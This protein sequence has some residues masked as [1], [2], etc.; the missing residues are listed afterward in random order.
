MALTQVTSDV[1][2]N[3]QANITQVGTLSNLTV[4]GNTSS[5]NVSATYLTGTI[6]TA[7]QT[8][9][10]GLGTVTTGTWSADTIPVNKGGTGS[11]STSGALDN[12]LPSGEVSGYVLATSGPGS[13]YWA[14][15]SGGGSTVGSQIAI[16]RTTY[17]ATAGQTV[18]SSTGTYTIGSNQLRVFI[19]GVR[20]FPSE[21]TETTT[22]SF[23]MTSG[24]AAG[25]LVMA[26][27][28]SYQNYTIYANA[29]VSSA[30]GGVAATNVQDALSELDTEKASLSGATF[31]GNVT[32]SA[33]VK[34]TGWH[35]YESSN[36]L[37]FA[38]NG[39]VKMSL[40]TAGNLT[41][42]GDVAGFG[43]P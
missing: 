32:T 13:Y 36:N 1:L 11:T 18:F 9:I 3:S 38:Y 17:T 19:N 23:T 22:T 7:S 37:Y 41:V 31:T 6:T 10:T 4:T 28:D 40:N 16:S 2:N 12:L 26:E 42:T 14:A 21:Y 20:Q 35:I 29:V 27:V 8:N 15:Q 5:G 34:F 25:D 33:N 30:V 43:T 39:T 24:L